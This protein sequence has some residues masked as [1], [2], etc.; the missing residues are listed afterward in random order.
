MPHS[1]SCVGLGTDKRPYV[2]WLKVT[3]KGV[4]VCDTFSYLMRV[5]SIKASINHFCMSDACIIS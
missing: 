5:Y 4:F 1:V 3:F 2:L